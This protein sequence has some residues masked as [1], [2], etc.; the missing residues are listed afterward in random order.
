M[1]D[2]ARVP[3]PRRHQG[4]TRL[5]FAL[6]HW[7]VVRASRMPSLTRIDPS[8]ALKC[9]LF[10]NSVTTVRLQRPQPTQPASLRKDS[11]RV[12]CGAE[13]TLG[14]VEGRRAG[15]RLH[16]R[17]SGSRGRV[18]IRASATLTPRHKMHIRPSPSAVAASPCTGNR[19]YATYPQGR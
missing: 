11:A 18:R 10:D 7:A 12:A 17:A 15:P 4:C 6:K 9:S 19:D 14:A 3:L 13:P 5:L 1:R 2:T 8:R 16:G